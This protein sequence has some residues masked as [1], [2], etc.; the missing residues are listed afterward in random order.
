MTTQTL[1]YHKII[2]ATDKGVLI[3]TKD[4][5]SQGYWVS[6][7]FAR[8]TNHTVIVPDKY[9]YPTIVSSDVPSALS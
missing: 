3:Q 4:G 7:K 9:A 8:F 1:P 2:R 6:R 5:S